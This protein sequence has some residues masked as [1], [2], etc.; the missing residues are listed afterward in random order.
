M[1]RL[2]GLAMNAGG[3]LATVR[4][5]IAVYI[6]LPIASI[7][8]ITWAISWATGGTFP[9][10][11]IHRQMALSSAKYAVKLR[12]KDPDSA[13][14]ERVRYLPNDAVCGKVNAKNGLGGY[15][16]F[17]RFV[18]GPAGVSLEEDE[19]FWDVWSADCKG[20]F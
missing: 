7:F 4:D 10:K 16:G 3:F 11:F 1:L 19:G 20:W 17:Q 18:N 5:R 9:S 15:T 2:M 6:L 8:L 13:E 14:F 12:L